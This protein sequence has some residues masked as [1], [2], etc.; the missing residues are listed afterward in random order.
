MAILVPSRMDV[1]EYQSYL[2]DVSSIAGRI[3]ARYANV[4]TSWQPINLILGENYPRALAAMKWYDVLMVNPLRDGLNLVAKE[5]PACNRRDGVLCL[6]PEAGA[7][8]EL[9]PAAIEMHPYDLE[10]AAGALD[11]ALGLP[12]DE[13]AARA[14]HLRKLATMRTPDD[15]LRDLVRHARE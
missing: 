12:L 8:E 9:H 2:D 13:R 11:T 1:V 15:W 14:S 6:S 4:E 5:G 3:N 7:F 10:Q